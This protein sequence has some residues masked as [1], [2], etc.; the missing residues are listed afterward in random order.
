M[1][2]AVYNEKGRRI[3]EGFQFSEVSGV[4]RL[5]AKENDARDSYPSHIIAPGFWSRI[6]RED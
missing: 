4:V 2:Y 3:G 5:Y 1:P 6:E